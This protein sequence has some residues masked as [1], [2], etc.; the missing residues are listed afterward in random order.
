MV[1]SDTPL[2]RFNMLYSLLLSLIIVVR[3]TTD[4]TVVASIAVEFSRIVLTIAIEFKYIKSNTVFILYLVTMAV[5]LQI[6]ATKLSLHR[7][8]KKLFYSAQDKHQNRP[9]L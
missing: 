8:L 9:R 6:Y 3:I 2:R 5:Q 7:S 4:L 1:K